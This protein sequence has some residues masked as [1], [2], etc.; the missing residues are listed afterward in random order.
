ML[1][2]GAQHGSVSLQQDQENY[3]FTLLNFPFSYIPCDPSQKT[4]SFPHTQQTLFPSII[5]LLLVFL[6]GQTHLLKLLLAVWLS[7]LIMSNT[8]EMGAF[9]KD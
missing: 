6:Y 3:S 8:L 9:K 4:T 2:Y 1:K 7:V 5:V